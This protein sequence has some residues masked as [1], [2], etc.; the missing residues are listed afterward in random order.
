MK[1]K[2]RECDNGGKPEGL[3]EKEGKERKRECSGV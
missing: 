3:R 2:E 1:M